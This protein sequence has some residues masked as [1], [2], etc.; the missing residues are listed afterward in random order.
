M[1]GRRVLRLVC[2]ALRAVRQA[3]P[4]ATR[5]RLRASARKKE[6]L[7]AAKRKQT[8]AICGGCKTFACVARG[9][10][11]GRAATADQLKAFLTGHK[12]LRPSLANQ[13]TKRMND[14]APIL[15]SKTKMGLERWWAFLRH[16]AIGTPCD[17]MRN[18][19]GVNKNTVTA[20]YG[21]CGRLAERHASDRRL[22]ATRGQVDETFIGKR[23]ANR[24]RRVR[25]QT[26]WFWTFTTSDETVWELAGEGRT[27]EAAEA[28]VTKHCAGKRAVVSTDFHKSYGGLGEGICV[29]KKV[30]HSVEFVTEDGTHINGAEAAHSAVKRLI[31]RR[32]NRYGQS[33]K[34]VVRK[35]AIGCL[36]YRPKTKGVKQSVVRLQRLLVLYR[37]YGHVLLTHD[38]A[39][40]PAV[41][42]EKKRG[43]PRLPPSVKRG[44]AREYRRRAKAKKAAKSSEVVNKD[45][46]QEALE[47]VVD[48]T[49]DEPPLAAGD[50]YAELAR[51]SERD[52]PRAR[53]FAA[54]A[55]SGW[56]V[57]SL[58]LTAMM[59]P[60]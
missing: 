17:A 9:R 27:K 8:G 19:M 52:V 55:K 43:R 26:C 58:V 14:L 47:G 16:V 10:A 2:R 1:F 36:L 15:S 23:V 22:E 57:S 25:K 5:A 7:K 48:L 11:P 53:Q 60:Q 46:V 42:E 49:Q 37:D 39:E 50:D 18:E 3:I 31:R 35:V 13:R 28:F 54:A 4:K 24:G 12:V 41:K 44:R 32:F 40:E 30:N 51:L 6:A 20:L 56:L 33:I 29:H 34:D 21:Q 38:D 45:A 59:R